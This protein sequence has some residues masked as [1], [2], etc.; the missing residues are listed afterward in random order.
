MKNNLIPFPNSRQRDERRA[1]MLES[2][3]ELKALRAAFDRACIGWPLEMAELPE[4][5]KMYCGSKK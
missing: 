2:S 4:N 3:N 1:K 5:N